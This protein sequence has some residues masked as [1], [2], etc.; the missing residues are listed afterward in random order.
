MFFTPAP[1]TGR[2]AALTALMGLLATAAAATAEDRPS[3]VAASKADLLAMTPQWK[4][5][6]LSDGRPKVSDDLLRRMRSISTEDAWEILRKH[7]YDNNFEG[8]WKMLNP[9]EAFV[10][11]ARPTNASSGFSIFQPP[12][13][14]LS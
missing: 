12:S 4:G 7:G 5:D 14:L 3:V 10:G 11:R 9:D 8:G 1:T 6:R 2:I 13:K